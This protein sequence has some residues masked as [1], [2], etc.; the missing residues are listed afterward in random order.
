MSFESMVEIGKD[1]CLNLLKT[2]LQT[3]DRR[4]CND[5]CQELIPVFQNPHRK[6]RPSL[7]VVARTL[8]YLLWQPTKASSSGRQKKQIRIHIQKVRQYLECGN[9]I[10]PKSSP[11]H[12]MKA[13]SLQSIFVGKGTYT[14]NQPC[15]ES[16]N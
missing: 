2:L 4:S 12:G 5:G 10:S 7:S 16:F 15:S 13:E 14:T 1:F 3:F 11:R 8:E 6:G 9:Q